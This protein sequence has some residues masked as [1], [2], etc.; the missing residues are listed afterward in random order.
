LLYTTAFI[1]KFGRNTRSALEGVGTKAFKA[2]NITG[3]AF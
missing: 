3:N 2:G 1:E